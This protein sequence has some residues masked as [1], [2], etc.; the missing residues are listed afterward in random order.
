M[1]AVRQD[2]RPHISVVVLAYNSAEFLR[3]CLESL[4]LATGGRH[5]I[6]IVDNA[7]RDATLTVAKAAIADLPIDALLVPLS[8][9]RGCAGGNNAGWRAASGDFIV[10]LNPDTEIEPAC[11]EQLIEPMLHDSRI[12]ITGAKI[13]Y[14]ESRRLQHAGGILHPNGMSNHYGAG[15][16]DTG[17]HDTMRDC[18]Y[19]TGAGFAVRR[20]LLVDLKGFDED[21]F[22]AYFEET[23]L[24][25]RAAMRG[26]RIVYNPAA[27]LYHHESVSLV[28]N[29]PRFRRL[30]QR[31]RILFCIKN[32]GLRDWVRFARFEQ[33]WMRR[34]PAARGHRL[35]QFRAYA[36]GL[37]WYLRTRLRPVRQRW[38]N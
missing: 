30:Y 37:A 16:E 19:V 18:A 17:Q 5:Q 10:F 7:S 36:E 9:N 6:V 15:E 25:R 29:S 33:W 21:F 4:A 24:C 12:G 20:S 34:E 2:L 26:W 13:Y 28:V 11:I 1:P 3:P 31:M 22:P 38:K 23:D 32:Y 27:V 35:E 14:P 8:G